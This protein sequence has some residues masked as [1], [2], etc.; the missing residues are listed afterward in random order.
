MMKLPHF[1][2]EICAQRYA[3][4]RICHAVSSATR[5]KQGVGLC[6]LQQ[7]LASFCIE[8]QNNRIKT[9]VRAFFQLDFPYFFHFS[10]DKYMCVMAHIEHAT[11]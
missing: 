3:N 9:G 1:F 11:Y 10:L 2:G 6:V 7:P 8:S 4:Q 5:V